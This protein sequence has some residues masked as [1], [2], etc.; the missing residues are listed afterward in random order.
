MA[1]QELENPLGSLKVTCR[2]RCSAP[3]V[4]ESSKGAMEAY[5]LADLDLDKAPSPGRSFKQQQQGSGALN[6]TY[7]DSLKSTRRY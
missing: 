5:H 1:L 2:Q 3:L 7:L 4:S 6:R